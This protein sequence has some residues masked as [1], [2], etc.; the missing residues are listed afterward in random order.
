MA[1]TPR[2]LGA[3]RARFVFLVHPLVRSARRLAALRTG[4]VRL[5]ATDRPTI[6]DIAVYARIGFGE[7]E[8]VVVGL[9]LLPDEL[10]ADQARALLWM[11]RAVQIAAPVGHV[12]LGSV[13]AV[14]AGRGTALAEACGLPV[15]TGNAATAWAATSITHRIAAGRPVAVLGGRGAVGRAVADVL[16]ADGLSVAVDPVDVSAY[17]VVVGAHTTGGV[18]APSALHPRATLVDVA[19]PPTLSGPPPAGV[20]VLAGESVALPEGWRRDVWGHLFHV[21]A[22]YGWTGV[23]ACVL[24]PLIAARI[25]R[26]TPFAQGRRLDVAAVRAFGAA[27]EH[28]GFHPRIRRLH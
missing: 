5:L 18:L 11:E 13:L 15:T 27:A 16:A 1:P 8:G 24:E 19:L 10:L 20:T 23:Y 17:E 26:E 9:P 4:R 2:V 21:V 22:G 7:V 25:G 14:V 28:A 6:D 3:G 12:G